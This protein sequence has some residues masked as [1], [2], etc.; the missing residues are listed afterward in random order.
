MHRE[1]HLWG[2]GKGEGEFFSHS[3]DILSEGA[4]EPRMEMWEGAI[5]RVQWTEKKS[6]MSTDYEAL[7]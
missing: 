2:R 7:V 6:F 5:T 1:A 3:T 4:S